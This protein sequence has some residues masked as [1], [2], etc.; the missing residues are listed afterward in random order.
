LIGEIRR[1]SLDL[2]HMFGRADGSIKLFES[3]YILRSYMA[4]I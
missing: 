3:S 1:E 4:Q 2:L